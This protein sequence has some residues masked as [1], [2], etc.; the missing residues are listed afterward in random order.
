MQHKIT[1]TLLAAIL[2]AGLTISIAY[3]IHGD[4]T[5]RTQQQ[6]KN[7]RE[8]QTYQARLDELVPVNK[9]INNTIG[10]ANIADDQYRILKHLQLPPGVQLPDN[11][12][13][14][15]G[16]VAH[17]HESRP[18]G[19]N[20]Y[21]ILTTNDSLQMTVSDIPTAYAAIQTLQARPDLRFD[22]ATLTIVNKVPTLTLQNFA[23]LIR[24][25]N[26]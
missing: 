23:V 20:R 18:L 26:Q 22:R 24:T 13:T 1:P 8:W 3:D 2:I 15:T 6:Q 10:P 12:I 16:P 9:E 21:G 19:I 25:D 4:I 17:Q 7:T 14:I 5:K 11:N